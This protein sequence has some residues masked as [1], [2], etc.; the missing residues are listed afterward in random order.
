MTKQMLKIVYHSNFESLVRYGCIFYGNN[1]N[2][3]TVLILQ[4]QALRVINNRGFRDSCRGVFKKTGILTIYGIYI[5]ECALFV[6]KN[7]EYFATQITDHPYKTRNINY[8]YPKHRLTLT[9]KNVYYSCITTYN[10][11]PPHI[12]KISTLKLFKKTLFKFL[13]NLEPYTLNEYHYFKE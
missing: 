7:R 10:K 13:L 5:Q 6:F 8:V 9:E 11:L 3:E 12:K 4:K 2:M 1:A